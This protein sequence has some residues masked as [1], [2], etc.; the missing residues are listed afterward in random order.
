MAQST[1]APKTARRVRSDRRAALAAAS[2][3]AG[4]SA[5]SAAVQ[6]QDANSPACSAAESSGYWDRWIAIPASA[7][8]ATPQASAPSS[9]SRSVS[10]P[11]RRS[12]VA[13]TSLR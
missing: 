13:V 5:P 4:S 10:A 1:Q 11:G 2:T 12:P 6:T 8:P 7:A 3:S 9:P